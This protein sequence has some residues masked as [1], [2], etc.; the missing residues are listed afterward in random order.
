M[1]DSGK[2]SK[3]QVAKIPGPETVPAEVQETFFQM[4]RTGTKTRINRD[5]NYKACQDKLICSNLSQL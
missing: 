1:L 4:L 3:E 5:S 2:F